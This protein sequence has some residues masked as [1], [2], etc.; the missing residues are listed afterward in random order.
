MARSKL[1]ALPRDSVL[2]AHLR[3]QA[4][5]PDDAARLTRRDDGK[6]ARRELLDAVDRIGRANHLKGRADAMRAAA[7]TLQ[8]SRG[9]GGQ[10]PQPDVQAEIDREE[11]QAAELAEQARLIGNDRPAPATAVSGRKPAARKRAGRPGE[12]G[13]HSGA[14]RRRTGRADRP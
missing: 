10:A 14:Q 7:E 12:R 5:W 1:N 2:R 6:R 11:T 3:R 4:D 13:R 8:D 9:A